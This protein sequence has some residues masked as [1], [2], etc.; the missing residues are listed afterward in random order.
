M[1]GQNYKSLTWAKN[2][3]KNKKMSLTVIKVPSTYPPRTLPVPSPYPPRT[4]PVPSLYPPRTLPVPSPRQGTE[5]R[6]RDVT[7]LQ[8]NM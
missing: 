3:K 5:M 4:L 1:I 6:Q 7:Y 2:E 8:E